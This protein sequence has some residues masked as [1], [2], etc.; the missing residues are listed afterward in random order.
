M[1]RTN[2]SSIINADGTLLIPMSVGWT[3]IA[4]YPT[5]YRG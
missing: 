3:L 4:L 1:L 5:K 2:V